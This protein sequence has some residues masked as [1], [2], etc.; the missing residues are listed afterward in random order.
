MSRLTIVHDYLLVLRGAERTVR[1][2]ATEWPDAA[3]ATLVADPTVATAVFGSRPVQTSPLQRFGI[4]QQGFRRWLMVYPAAV[5]RL[6]LTGTEIVLSSTS[7][8]AHAVRVPEGATHISYCY[9]PFRYAWHER[10]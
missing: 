5:R 6:D 10:E 1:A 8:F 2:M 7:A 9:T 4:R 3:A